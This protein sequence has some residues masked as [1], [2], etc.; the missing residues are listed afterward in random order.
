M[1]NTNLFLFLFALLLTQCT[2]S[3]KEATAPELPDIAVSAADFDT[4]YKGKEIKLFSLINKSGMIVQVCNY[5]ARIVSILIPGNDGGY[6]D[7]VLGYNTIGEYL[8]DPMNQGCVVGRYA[9]RIA[10]G[11]FELDGAAF[12]LEINNGENTLHSGSSTYSKV[13]WDV[14][15]S[16][17]SVFMHYV[18]PHMDGGFPGELRVTVAYVLTDNNTLEL[19]Y[20]AETS[21]KTVVNF[22]NHAYFNLAGEGSGD[23]SNQY[24]KINGDFI[25]P[26]NSQMIPTGDLMP[27]DNTPFDLRSEVKIGKMIDDTH[28]QLIFGKGYDHNWVLTKETPGTLS[29]AAS[30]RD[31][32]TGIQLNVYT[33]EPGIQFYTGNFMNGTVS[34]KSGSLYAARNGFALEAQH[35]PDS[36]NH[37]NFPSTVLEP[38]NKYF[39]KTVLEFNF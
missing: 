33:T 17:D 28:E 29:L 30:C 32:G 7:V 14:Y 1:K 2:F 15:H 24:I 26:V 39:Q 37:P 35:F 9:N 22:T 16:G 38:G 12:Q 10:K 34:G 20:E 25:T 6:R 23:I 19:T 36:P 18:S 21:L 31:E 8:N 4:I 5:G 11:R 27:V 3:G 13:V